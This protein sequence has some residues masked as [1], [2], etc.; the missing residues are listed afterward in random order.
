MP[1]IHPIRTESDYEKALQEIDGLISTDPDPNTVEGERLELLSILIEDYEEKHYPVPL[2]DDPVEVILYFMEKNGLT[3][4]DLEAYLGSKARVSEVLNRKRSLSLTM[5]RHL[6]SGLGI[7]ADFLIP[8]I[9]LGKKSSGS[10][11][12]T[13]PS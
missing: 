5:I 1:D 12:F 10:H 3:R 9:N 6:S 11:V 2:P 8:R 4:K 13:S 7:P